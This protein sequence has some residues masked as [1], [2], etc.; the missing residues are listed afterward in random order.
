MKSEDLQ[1]TLP[2]DQQVVFGIRVF[3]DD[4]GVFGTVSNIEGE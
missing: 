2:I 1:F 4:N 3:T